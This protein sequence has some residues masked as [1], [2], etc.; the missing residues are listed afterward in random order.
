METRIQCGQAL[1]TR[2]YRDYLE[3]LIFEH[4]TE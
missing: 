3:A 1:L 4:A 2:G